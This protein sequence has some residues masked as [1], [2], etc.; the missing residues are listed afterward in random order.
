MHSMRTGVC[1]TDVVECR[2]NTDPNILDSGRLGL[3]DETGD[4]VLSGC[5]TTGSSLVEVVLRRLSDGRV[6][7]ERS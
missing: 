5:S 3:L 1:G 4:F 7:G 2:R 6:R